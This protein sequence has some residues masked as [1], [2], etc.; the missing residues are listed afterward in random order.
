M[1][2]SMRC[3]TMFLVIA[4]V[5][6]LGLHLSV[7]QAQEVRTLSIPAHAL[8]VAPSGTIITPTALG[9]QWQRNFQAGARFFVHRP[10][11][12]S[13]GDVTFSIFFQTT[14]ETAGVVDFFIRPDSFNS[15]EGFE[16]I[17]NL[18]ASGV[19]VSGRAGFG[20]LYEQQFTIPASRLA[21]DWWTSNIQREGETS[22][23]MDDVIVLAVALQYQGK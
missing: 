22:T 4:M 11:D 21:G 7:A 10:S 3:S 8:S 19:S 15:G 12:Y 20:T 13:G 14:S 23:Y 5:C 17:I 18:S 6:G 2:S 16:D 9:L 1:R